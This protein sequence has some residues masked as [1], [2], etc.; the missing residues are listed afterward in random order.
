MD[1]ILFVI[2]VIGLF[3]IMGGTIY[4]EWKRMMDE[5]D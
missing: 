5:D 1:K 4:S 3:A 2:T